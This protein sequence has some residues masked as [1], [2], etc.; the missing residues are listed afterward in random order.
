MP[1]K[2]APGKTNPENNSMP[3]VIVLFV[4]LMGAY[5]L[6]KKEGDEII[7]DYTSVVSRL[8]LAYGLSI[9]LLYT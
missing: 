1:R 5:F 6:T 3:Y 8:N 9:R 4:A 2:T 7:P